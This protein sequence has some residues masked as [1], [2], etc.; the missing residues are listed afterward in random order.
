MLLSIW[1]TLGSLFRRN[2]FER[3]STQTYQPVLL[4]LKHWLVSMLSLFLDLLL[5]MKGF[6]I[7]NA[8]SFL[9]Q[10]F[11]R[12]SALKGWMGKHIVNIWITST[13]TSTLTSAFIWK[14]WIICRNK[15]S[16]FELHTDLIAGFCEHS[17]FKFLLFFHF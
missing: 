3:R 1:K 5:S 9:N 8:I 4:S 16:L 13:C 12:S 11:G 6:M 10:I 15:Y 14:T 7:G 2:N 17:F